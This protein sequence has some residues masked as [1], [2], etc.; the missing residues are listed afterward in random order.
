MGKVYSAYVCGAVI[1]SGKV[2]WASV[3]VTVV[4]GVVGIV[5]VATV[6]LGAVG[7]VIA[8]A[9]DFGVVLVVVLAP[10][11][12]ADI[13][14]AGNASKIS[15]NATLFATFFGAKLLSFR[16]HALFINDINAYLTF[17]SSC[18][19]SIERQDPARL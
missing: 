10:Q 6:G 12:A 1:N 7:A 11:L 17:I 8:T 15:V 16:L 18:F 9:A 13:A 4:F 14:K 2:V 5:V 3:G 19:V